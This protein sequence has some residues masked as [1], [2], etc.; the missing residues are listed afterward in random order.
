MEICFNTLRLTCVCVKIKRQIFFTFL[1]SWQ[2]FASGLQ[3]THKWLANNGKITSTTTTTTTTTTFFFFWTWQQTWSGMK[4][5]LLLPLLLLLL[6]LLPH[7]SPGVSYT[8]FMQVHIFS[9]HG[10]QWC[11][12][13]GKEIQ[14]EQSTQAK[15]G[16]HSWMVDTKVRIINQLAI[17][18]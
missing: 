6:L 2:M 14:Y 18:W 13:Q 5:L 16:G 9:N 15:A 1:P 4:L 12:A 7:V 3:A 17:A 8:P 11:H 10:G